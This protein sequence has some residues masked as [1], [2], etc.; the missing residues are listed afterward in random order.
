MANSNIYDQYLPPIGAELN[1]RAEDKTFL[2]DTLAPPPAP[3][4]D[5]AFVICRID[6]TPTLQSSAAG[7][8]TT[9]ATVGPPCTR[10]SNASLHNPKQQFEI[11]HRMVNASRWIWTSIRTE[12]GS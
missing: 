12:P 11:A 8:G 7:T 4:D 9:T 2:R 1:L 6:G 10:C 3:T 5:L